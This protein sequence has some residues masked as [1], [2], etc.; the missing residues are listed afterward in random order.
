MF[1]CSFSRI[2]VESPGL[3]LY[4]FFL[5]LPVFHLYICLYYFCQIFLSLYYNLSYFYFRFTRTL[6]FW[7]FV[8]HGILILYYGY[9]VFSYFSKY[10]D[11]GSNFFFFSLLLHYFSSS[12]FYF[13]VYLCLFSGL[14][15]VSQISDY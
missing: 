8:F 7:L 10:V 11:G 13:P 2:P 5:F 1:L 9:H 4:I 3:I 12:R 6:Y 14:F 15:L